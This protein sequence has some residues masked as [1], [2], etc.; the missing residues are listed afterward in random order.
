M[1]TFK[2]KINNLHN[3]KYPRAF[4]LVN[5]GDFFAA[6]VWLNKDQAD[7]LEEGD[8][9][10]VQGGVRVA[11]ATNGGRDNI[12]ITVAKGE[13]QPLWVARDGKWVDIAAPGTKPSTEAYPED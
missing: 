12:S 3:D 5:D 9:I 4:V 6:T 2:G 13:S 8:L 10:K 11:A 7:Q 1:N